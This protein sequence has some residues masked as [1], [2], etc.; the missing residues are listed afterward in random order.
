MAMHPQQLIHLPNASTC[1]AVCA[2]SGARCWCSESAHADWLLVKEI[3]HESGTQHE[4]EFSSDK[5]GRS[6]DRFGGGR[7]AMEPESSGRKQALRSFVRQ[8]ADFLDRAIAARQFRYLVLIA[9]PKVLGMLRDS[10]SATTK[11]SVVC[12]APKNLANLD[13]SEI[14]KYFA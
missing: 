7:H 14:R 11:K 4:A 10:L 9:E 5:P 13:V 8:L 2:A 1:I 12:E 3:R 6:F